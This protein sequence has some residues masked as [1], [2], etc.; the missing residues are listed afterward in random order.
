[1]PHTLFFFQATAIK[2]IPEGLVLCW[3]LWL[4]VQLA[5]KHIEIMIRYGVHK[6]Q[7]FLILSVRT[8]VD[9]WQGSHVHHGVH[10]CVG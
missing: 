8:S 1:M 7:H 4:Q 10:M 3:F 6:N 5:V 2:Q 9:I